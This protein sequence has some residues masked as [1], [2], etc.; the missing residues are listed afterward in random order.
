MPR[1]PGNQFLDKSFATEESPR[2]TR[3]ECGQ[4]DIRGRF[5]IRWGNR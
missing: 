5:P 1:K 3:P 4:A 2:V